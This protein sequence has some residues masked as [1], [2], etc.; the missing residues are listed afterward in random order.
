MPGRGRNSAGLPQGGTGRPRRAD[1]CRPRPQGECRITNSPRLR[2][3][4]TRHATLDRQ[5]TEE[6]ARP[7]P[8]DAELSRLKREKLKLKEAMEKLRQAD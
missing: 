6:D 8:E 1:A 2:T 4:E 5:I 3:L 7:R